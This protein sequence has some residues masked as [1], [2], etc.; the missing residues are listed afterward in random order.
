MY[1]ILSLRGIS[2]LGFQKPLAIQYPYIVWYNYKYSA[3]PLH[4]DYMHAHTHGSLD[5]ANTHISKAPS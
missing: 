3:N 2:Y 1:H 5:H 4:Q